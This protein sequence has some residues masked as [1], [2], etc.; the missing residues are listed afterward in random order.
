[1]HG[2][3]NISSAIG[4]VKCHAVAVRQVDWAIPGMTAGKTVLQQFCEKRLMLFATSRNDPTKE[5][6]SNL[7]PWFH[8]GTSL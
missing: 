6:L 1:M 2:I 4:S 5:A 8:F 3:R 7:S